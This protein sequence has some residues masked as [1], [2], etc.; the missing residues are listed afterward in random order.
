MWRE[1]HLGIVLAPEG[2]ADCAD[3]ASKRFAAG[4]SSTGAQTTTL[5]EAA[6]QPVIVGGDV[7]CAEVEALFTADSSL[8]SVLVMLPDRVTVMPRGRFA[9][10][11]VGPLGYGRAL[12]QRRP[13]AA[14]A[15]GFALVL[16]DSTG[17]GRAADLAM[18]RPEVERYD[19]V[20]VAAGDGT[21]GVVSVGSLLD[22]LAE[23]FAE[24]AL[25]DPLTGL[26]NRRLL[27]QRLGEAVAEQSPSA[28]RTVALVVI[29][30]DG[31]KM[32]ND[33]LGHSAGDRLLTHIAVRLSATVRT[34]DMVARLGGDEFAV[35]IDTAQPVNLDQLVERM[36][37]AVRRPLHLGG[38]DI[39][40]TGS[41]GLATLAHSVDSE[42][43]LRRADVAMY[44]AKRAGG[45][46]GS[47]YSVELAPTSDERLDMASALRRAIRNDELVVHYQPK[48]D[49]V[50]GRWAEVEALVRWPQ[51]DGTIL[52]PGAFIPLAEQSDLIVDLGRTILRTACHDVAAWRRD[53]GIE[54]SVCVNVAARQLE[55]GEELIDDVTRALADSGLHPRHL[56]LELTE[57]ALFSDWRAATEHLDS[58]RSTGVRI[59][60]DD[61][62]TGYSSLT[63]L[64]HLPID[65]LKIDRSLLPAQHDTKSA[66]ILRLIVGCAHEM[67]MTVT[68]EGVETAWQ[69]AFVSSA[70][71]DLVQGYLHAR[72]MPS[73]EFLDRVFRVASAEGSPH[74]QT[75]AHAVAFSPA[76]HVSPSDPLLVE[77]AP[78]S[79]DST[80]RL[81]SSHW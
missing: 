76:E 62:G 10:E 46:R 17:L 58:L 70:G 14:L 28:T 67:G 34:G 48:V 25:Y 23:H 71:C 42:E 11:Y 81:S 73:D 26:P 55:T 33:S 31:F 24:L 12:Y 5:K 6:D 7:R 36:A 19:D 38:E 18:Q 13:I 66:A 51:P 2:Y 41:F 54:L 56:C 63:R 43:L 45:N 16:P 3:M 29:D 47:R 44:R 37:S 1:V 40:V 59:A 61:F 77:V 22:S 57:S 32:V 8:S 35:L 74:P 69:H 53:L 30:L 64:M 75:D 79:H 78:V 65:E 39:E 60:M 4:E 15:T 68:A 27:A 9:A 21:Y 20:V 49:V 72:P 50:T 80:A 52:G